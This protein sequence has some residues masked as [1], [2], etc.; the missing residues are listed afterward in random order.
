MGCFQLCCSLTLYH[1]TE[2]AKLRCSQ[3]LSSAACTSPLFRTSLSIL[4]LPHQRSP[5]FWDYPSFL[6]HGEKIIRKNNSQQGLRNQSRKRAGLKPMEWQEIAEP[7]PISASSNPQLPSS[8]PSPGH[9]HCLWGESSQG[10]AGPHSVC[11]APCLHPLGPC[12]WH[13]HTRF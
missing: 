9:L 1:P 11:P 5:N 10:W 7:S 12:L 3:S 4:L 13:R 8:A 2:P 6:G